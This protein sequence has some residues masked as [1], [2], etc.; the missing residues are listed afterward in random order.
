MEISF[1]NQLNFKG[2][3]YGYLPYGRKLTIDNI[4]GVFMTIQMK[5]DTINGIMEAE[6][7]RIYNDRKS[8]QNEIYVEFSL[9][10]DNVVKPAI[11]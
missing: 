7:I 8:P 11:E 9:E 6:H 5:Y 2:G 1:G 4:D 3:I 10:G